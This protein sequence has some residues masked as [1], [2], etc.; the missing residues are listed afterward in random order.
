L[1]AVRDLIHPY[2]AMTR[3]VPL[4]VTISA[5]TCMWIKGDNGAGKSTLL[6]LIAGVLPIEIG[7][8]EVSVPFSYL[9]AELGL[10]TH[11]TLK[12]YQRFAKVLGAECA[13][14]LP[15]NRELDSF[16]SGQKLWIRLQTTLRHDRPLWLLDEPTRFLD[17]THEALLWDKLK[18]HCATGGA[19]VVASHSPVTSWISDC[20]ILELN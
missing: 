20:Q 2:I 3:S 15:Q 9:G 14:P 17:T 18:Q 5:G 1:L 16:S 10:K 13:S 11:A 6:K 19:V 8:L 12:D 7:H 4:S